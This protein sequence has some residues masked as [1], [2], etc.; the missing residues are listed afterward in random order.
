MR[1]YVNNFD[2][3]SKVWSV[4]EGPGTEERHYAHIDTNSV[5]IEFK[6]DMNAAPHTA[7]AWIEPTVE[8]VSYETYDPLRD[9]KTLDVYPKH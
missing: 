6:V 4:D 9:S 2:D 8:V 3:R 1:I 7:R 5:P